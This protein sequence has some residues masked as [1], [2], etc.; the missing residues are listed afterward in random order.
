MFKLPKSTNNSINR[1]QIILAVFLLLITPEFI[2]RVLLFRPELP[3]MFLGM[4]AFIFFNKTRISGHWKFPV[5]A[6]IFS[7][8]TFLGH[9]NAVIFPVAGFLLLLIH[10]Q[11]KSLVLF[12]IPCFLTC[13]IYTEGLW[14]EVNF[15]EYVYELRNWPSHSFKEKVDG[16]LISSVFSNIIGLLNE[17]KRYFWD[18]NVWIISG[19]FFISLMLYFKRIR[20]ESPFLI[21]YVVLLMV[22]LGLLGGGHAPRYLMFIF[23]YMA[24]ICARAIQI[25]SQKER[26]FNIVLYSIIIVGQLVFMVTKYDSIFNKKFDFQEWNNEVLANIEPNSSVI[27]PWHLIYNNINQYHIINY[28]TFEY[29]EEKRPIKFSQLEVLE[30]V[31][32]REVDFIILDEQMKKD[33]VMHWFESWKIV[34]NPYYE[35]YKRSESYLILKRI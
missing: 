2:E 28:K 19:A 33:K 29:R 10:K 32:N 27:G 3:V 9:L 30:D 12:S 20:R 21:D 13:L 34:E 35:E 5:L 18:Q 26:K 24:L 8:I 4:I 31:F 22:L 6:G 11:W 15:T 14:F 1:D 17:H 23:P 25:S 7:G 16:G